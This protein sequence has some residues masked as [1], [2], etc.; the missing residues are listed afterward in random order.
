MVSSKLDGPLIARVHALKQTAFAQSAQA[1]AEE[2]LARREQIKVIVQFRGALA[3]VEAA[4]LCTE[5]HT[6][7]VAVG[8]IAVA[9]LERVAAV[10]DVVSIQSDRTMRPHRPAPS[11]S[12]APVARPDDCPVHGPG[13]GGP[14]GPGQAADRRVAHIVGQTSVQ[15]QTSLRAQT[16]VQAQAHP[17]LPA[18]FTGKGVVVGVVDSGIDVFHPAFVKPGTGVPGVLPQTRIVSLLD[19]TLRQT[20]ECTGGPTGGTIAFAWRNPAGEDA[21]T[22]ALPLPL[23]AAALQSAL[24]GL[25]SIQAGNVAVTGGPLPATP[26]VVDFVGTYDGSRIDSQTISEIRPSWALTGGTNPQVTIRRGRLITESEINAAL[27]AATPQPFFSRDVLGHGTHVAGIAAGIGTLTQPCC[28]DDLPLG[29]APEA[30]LAV[31]RTN[32]LETASLKGVKHILDQPWLAPGVPKKCVVVNLSL[33]ALGTAGDGT[34]SFSTMLDDYLFGTT[35]RSIVVSAGNDGGFHTPP[36]PSAP[37]VIPKSQPDGGQHAFGRVPASGPGSTATQIRFTVEFADVKPNVFHLWY[38]GAGILS[39]NLTAPPTLP[40]GPSPTV[41]PSLTAAITPDP[42]GSS[43]LHVV[44]IG[45]AGDTTEH[46]VAYTY[47]LTTGPRDKRHLNLELRPPVHGHIAIGTWTIT[48]RETA[49]FETPYDIWFTKAD[50]PDPPG[51]FIRPDQNRTRTVNA[52]GAAR[53]VITVG[54]YDAENDKL[55]EFSSRG[56]TTDLHPKPDVCAP[57]VRVFSARSGGRPPNLYIPMY[58][59]SMAAPYVSGVVALMFQMNENL[60]N[61]TVLAQLMATCTAPPPP[62]SL[63]D[64]WGAGRVHPERAVNAVRPPPHGAAAHGA[65]GEPPV[66]PLAAYPAA[67]VPL[68]RRVQQVRARAETSAAGRLALSLVTAHYD[69]VARLVEDD[70]RVLVAWRRMHGPLVLRLLL[71]SE[72]NPEAPVPRTLDGVSV[73]DGLA[74]LLDELAR[75]GS[76]ALRADVAAHR[77]FA[78]ALPG[79][80]L[81]DLDEHARVS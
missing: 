50:P 72:L 77:A 8:T 29:I 22:A 43:T 1:R 46:L 27:Q 44:P 17:P 63:D 28:V 5:F 81:S 59:T 54:A 9:D 65:D 70:R 36:S 67:R 41:G 42:A 75:A 3:E 76:P 45:P 13:D 40:G 47:A 62:R 61:G 64:G 21:R 33:G 60:D 48:L 30:D 25:A 80:R 73:A 12:A 69:E 39:V 10:A 38:E 55:A 6:A 51:R 57:G 49:G 18:G 66:L 23:T 7:R 53:H 34:D 4:G 52:P 37:L 79:A 26:L 14:T 20:I 74:R 58:G 35:R 16:S 15:A 32:F 56:P 71:L 11:A 78:L 68:A 2:E 24:A 31:V 19:L